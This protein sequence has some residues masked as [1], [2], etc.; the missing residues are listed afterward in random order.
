MA[1]DIDAELCRLG[2]RRRGRRDVEGDHERCRHGRELDI[3]ERERARVGAEHAAARR[4]AE[5]VGLL[6]LLDR[7]A[8]RFRRALHVRLD[9]DVDG[10]ALVVARALAKELAALLVGLRGEERRGALLAVALLPHV[11]DL[12]RLLLARRDAQHVT[13]ARHPLQAEHVD[14]RAGR[15]LHRFDAVNHELA[16]AAP[17]RAGDDDVA[18]TQRAALHN[19]RRDG[20]EA[21]V[22]ARLNGDALGGAVRVGAQVEHLG[23]ERDL[24]LEALE[25]RP[26]LGR[27]FRGEHVAAKPLE[28]D[29]VVEQLDAD[30]LDVCT[31]LVNLVD[32][33]DHGRVRSLGRPD[34]LDRLRLDAIVSCDDED[35]NVGHVGAARAHRGEGGVARRVQV[36]DPPALSRRDLVR[37]EV[38]R[39]PARLAERNA[40][41]AQRVEQR[42]LAMVNMSHHSDDGGP[43]HE[44]RNVVLLLL[45][46]A[47]LGVDVSAAR[48]DQPH[49]LRDGRRVR[50]RDRLRDRCEDAT[51]HQRLDDG[52]RA[53]LE[54]RGEIAD[55]D[56]LGD[57]HRRELDL[58]RDR[59]RVLA[60]ALAH[61]AALDP[62]LVVVVVVVAG[63]HHFA[64]VRRGLRAPLLLPAGGGATLGCFGRE[65]L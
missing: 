59:V 4:V 11:G 61:G 32:G 10:L 29:V 44:R 56:H 63:A 48:D 21:T 42:C 27:H 52:A 33:D 30:A 2:E 64:R 47:R 45:E 40:R 51:L 35:D 19:C 39:D 46:R 31:L 7:R 6:Q 3:L 22:H 23:E 41:L 65:A 58:D 17:L 49:P 37:A 25:A 13:R 60:P 9:H 1:H 16:H 38:L 54:K 20:P 43:G 50:A 55:G 15:R 18:D 34:R 24:L 28:H 12:L 5:R 36:R 8:Q 62:N 53:R 57:R 14:G 26:L